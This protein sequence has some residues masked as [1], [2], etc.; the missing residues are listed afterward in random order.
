MS[1]DRKLG[2]LRSFMFGGDV[3]LAPA[4]F[5]GH[6]RLQL[7]DMLGDGGPGVTSATPE[8]MSYWRAKMEKAQDLLPLP[9]DKLAAFAKEVA[10]PVKLQQIKAQATET[11]DNMKRLRESI[12]HMKAMLPDDA[13]NWNAVH[14]ELAKRLEVLAR[15]YNKMAIVIYGN[16]YPLNPV[17]Q[18]PVLSGEL[19]EVPAMAGFQFDPAMPEHEYS[20][21][22]FGM[23]Y[24][25]AASFAAEVEAYNLQRGMCQRLDPELDN[26]PDYCAK[27]DVFPSVEERDDTFGGT[28]RGLTFGEIIFGIPPLVI[29]A[30]V[31]L[32]LVALYYAYAWSKSSKAT[33]VEAEASSK[34]SDAAMAC[35]NSGGNPNECLKSAAAVAPPPSDS[36]DAMKWAPL[37]LGITGLLIGGIIIS[38]QLG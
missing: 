22:A 20:G 9:A 21:V 3:V 38:K 29:A 8:P 26:I 23:A 30:G 27:Y 2:P 19:H 12:D 24:Q 18:Q 13:K 10:N 17:T 32:T 28:Q 4:S 35:V 36:S 16:S 25:G 1:D 15:K 34:W 14:V 37:A 33:V 11:L 7:V 5:A 6:P 31:A